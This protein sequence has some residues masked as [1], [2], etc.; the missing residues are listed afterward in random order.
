MKIKGARV[1]IFLLLVLICQF[2]LLANTIKLED[3]YYIKL[4][5]KSGS[6]SEYHKMV[7]TPNENC[8]MEN[9]N[10]LE[11][12]VYLPLSELGFSIVNITDGVEN[13]FEPTASVQEVKEQLFY[14]PSPKKNFFRGEYISGLKPFA[15]SEEGL[16]YIAVDISSHWMV[17]SPIK[18]FNILGSA[19][20]G[21]WEPKVLNELTPIFSSDKQSAVFS[22]DMLEVR[23]GFFKFR[24]TDGWKITV[25]SITSNDCWNKGSKVYVNFG[26]EIGNLTLGGTNI[27]SKYNGVYSVKLFWISGSSPSVTFSKIM[28]IPQI[29]YTY[30]K[31]GIIGDAYN[32]PNGIRSQWRTNW[33]GLAETLVPA[34]E[35]LV[36][37][38]TFNGVKL[39]NNGH[40]KLRQ[41][42]D[43]TGLMFDY[44]D[45]T[46]WSGNAVNDFRN[47]DGE[48]VV[49]NEGSA[50]YNFVFKI[51]AETN[52]M[53]LQV[54]K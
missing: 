15:V 53:T 46:S 32:E 34:K 11:C 7:V 29:D 52:K 6:V 54:D 25:D 26:G 1:A 22:I 10:L 17:C 12:Y 47:M 19:I 18:T 9:K 16:Y 43:W 24:A 39:F 41:G 14:E 30:H 31:I 27:E 2:S 20:P 40:F 4:N 5:G 35:G 33:G 28:E 3:G 44:S 51:D 49:V 21:G 45:I 23:K 36:Y 37:T 48:F 50:V 13:C 8:W 42:S 38:W